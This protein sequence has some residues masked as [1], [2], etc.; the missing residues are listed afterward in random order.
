M[1]TCWFLDLLLVNYTWHSLFTAADVRCTAAS[2]R[3]KANWMMSCMVSEGSH[4]SMRYNTLWISQSA[5]STQTHTEVLLPVLLRIWFSGLFLSLCAVGV[6]QCLQVWLFVQRGASGQ[7]LR[8]VLF[9]Y[10]ETNSFVNIVSHIFTDLVSF[11]FPCIDLYFR[12]S[13]AHQLLR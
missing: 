8:V 12:L 10:S 2:T 6:S 7:L 13:T 9:L 1:Y 3:K 11:Q 4:C 5:T